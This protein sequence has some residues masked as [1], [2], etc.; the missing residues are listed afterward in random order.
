[1]LQHAKAFIIL[2][3]I[4]SS[5]SPPQDEAVNFIFIAETLQKRMTYQKS[6]ELFKYPCLKKKRT[7]LSS[8][9][10]FLVFKGTLDV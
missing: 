10:L 8:L 1:M 7:L 5:P 6:N 3:F 2:T 9:G 4:P